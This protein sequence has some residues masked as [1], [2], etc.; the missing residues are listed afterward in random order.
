MWIFYNQLTIIAKIIIYYSNKANKLPCMNVFRQTGGQIEREFFCRLKDLTV[1]LKY[2]GQHS[3]LG[4][5]IH[6]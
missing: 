2:Y 1:F 5:K 4:R 3:N 6:T